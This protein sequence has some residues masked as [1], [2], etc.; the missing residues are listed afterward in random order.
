MSR[1]R[2]TMTLEHG[3]ELQ[4]TLKDM[5]ASLSAAVLR[6]AVMDGMEPVRKRAEDLAPV[7]K[8]KLSRSMEKEI[9]EERPGFVAGHTGPN[10]DG[11]YGLMQEFGWRPAGKGQGGGKWEASNRVAPKPFLRPAVEEKQ[12]A[13]MAEFTR[14]VTAALDGVR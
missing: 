8:G 13:A 11:F 4:R 5:E 10:K 3:Q 9:V 12:D 6:D 14:A 1:A 7:L 2:V